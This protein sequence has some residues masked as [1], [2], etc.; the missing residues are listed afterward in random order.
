MSEARPP[1]PSFTLE[2]AIQ[3]VRTYVK[4]QNGR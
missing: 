3:K 1:L 2:A 4:A